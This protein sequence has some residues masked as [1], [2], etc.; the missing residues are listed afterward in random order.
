MNISVWLDAAK[1]CQRAT[2]LV[3]VPTYVT[4]QLAE[5]H[6]SSNLATYH[7]LLFSTQKSWLFHSNVKDFVHGD[8]KLQTCFFTLRAE[9]SYWKE[10]DKAAK[11]IRSTQANTKVWNEKHHWWQLQLSR[12]SSWPDV[13]SLVSSGI[14]TSC[15][16]WTF[17][18]RWHHLYDED[19]DQLVRIKKWRLV[20]SR[21]CTTTIVHGILSWTFLGLAG[22][23]GW[24]GDLE[25]QLE[26]VAMLRW[27]LWEGRYHGGHLL[28]C[29]T[30]S[31]AQHH[32]PGYWPT[33]NKKV[34]NSGFN[35]SAVCIA[36][37]GDYRPAVDYQRLQLQSTT[38][39]SFRPSTN[40]CNL[41]PLLDSGVAFAF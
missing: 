14:D 34:V 2:L 11:Y 9:N 3:R 20:S 10:N 5:L 41:I 27:D 7:N 24:V 35:C 4:A 30:D 40:P 28:L 16:S 26:T 19:Q 33:S 15:D 31:Q 1:R 29:D 36:S 13:M 8:R 22:L 17:G 21:W 23:V 6:F 37:G 39:N 18:V 12:M 25:W 32:W 38:M